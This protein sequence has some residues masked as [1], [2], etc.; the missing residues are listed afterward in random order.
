MWEKKGSSPYTVK[1][2]EQY[3]ELQRVTFWLLN[4]TT[5]V[6]GRVYYVGIRKSAKPEALGT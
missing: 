5:R 4:K 2:V 3:P 6:G 1:N